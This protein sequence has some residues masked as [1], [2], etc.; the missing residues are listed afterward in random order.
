MA[1]YVCTHPNHH[2]SMEIFSE[3]DYKEA[4]RI[5]D[6]YHVLLRAASRQAALEF[7]QEVIL[8]ALAMDPKLQ[9]LKKDI[10]E[11]YL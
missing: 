4:C 11:L 8:Q 7:V 6:G 5:D 2:G 9:D 10:Q 3:E 1:Y